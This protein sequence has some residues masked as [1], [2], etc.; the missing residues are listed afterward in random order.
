[1]ISAI[2]DRTVQ[3]EVQLSKTINM[4]AM[5]LNE[6]KSGEEYQEL[7]TWLMFKDLGGISVSLC[8][9]T[10]SDFVSIQL[11]ILTYVL[12]FKDHYGYWAY[13]S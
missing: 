1:M 5:H 8:W 11:H 3:S 9:Q 13:W 12:D 10:L 4:T 2:L 7:L 6:R